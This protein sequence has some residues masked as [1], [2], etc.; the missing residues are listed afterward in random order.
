VKAGRLQFANSP[1]RQFANCAVLLLTLSACSHPTAPTTA[2]PVSIDVLTYLLGDASLWPRHGSHNQEQVVDLA[3]REVCWVKYGNP[4]R[5]EC[6][7]WDDDYVYHAVDH[8]LDGDSNESYRFTDGR[9]LPRRLPA[10]ATAD[11]PWTL[12]VAQNQIVWYD[13]ACQIVP[14]RSYLFPYRMRAWIAPRLDAGPE[15][16]VRDT[17]QFDYEPYDPASPTPG[18]RE[19]YNLGFGAGWYEWERSGFVDYF[20]RVGGQATPMNAAVRCTGG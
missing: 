18:A 1:I 11:A 9:W 15:L 6:W 13:A 16:G 4:R 3:G 2:A 20:N 5:F 10:A 8:A 17:L 19:R 7:R 14:A 12:D